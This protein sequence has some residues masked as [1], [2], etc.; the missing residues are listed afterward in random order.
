MMT[1]RRRPA[2]YRVIRPGGRLLYD[3]VMRWY[4]S[5]V[6]TRHGWTFP[7]KVPYGF[8]VGFAKGRWEPLTRRVVERELFRGAVF[9]DIGANIGYYPRLASGIVGP[10]G[11]IFAFEPEPENYASLM[12]NTR[13]LGNVCAIAAAL[14]ERSGLAR[15]HLSTLA[16]CH[17]LV[18]STAEFTEGRDVWVPT[19]TVDEFCDDVR[20]AR[21]DLVKIDVEG[22]EPSVF[23]G[24]RRTLA[25]GAIRSMIVE[26]SPGNLGSDRASATEFGAELLKHFELTV[27][28][29]SK[30]GLAWDRVTD[31]DALDRLAAAITASNP[32]GCV[33][34]FG[35]S[36]VA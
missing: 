18:G 17:T 35:R 1:L 5:Y 4:S 28:E 29:T 3:L 15:L 24:M 26:Y 21:V 16:G 9:L 11:R 32:W 10:A 25:Q 12:Q 30:Y 33:N 13:T 36:R 20:L 2:V 23:R 8:R 34:L 6:S 14:S 27:I 19:L 22:A 7:A 31:V